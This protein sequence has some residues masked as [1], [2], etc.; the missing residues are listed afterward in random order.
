MVLTSPSADDMGLGKTLT[1]IAH[2]LRSA[3]LER[4]EKE[5]AS[6]DKDGSDKENT[7]EKEKD[8]K[9]KEEREKADFVDGKGGNWLSKNKPVKGTA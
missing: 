3:E 6:T 2:C 1:M 4:E 5:K 7:A 8:K 9:A